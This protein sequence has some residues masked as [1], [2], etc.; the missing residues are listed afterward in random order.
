M[1]TLLK[2]RNLALVDELTW[3]PERGFLAITGETGAGKS[4]IMGGISLVLGERADKGRIRSGES[5]CTV[6]AVFHLPHA[7]T[8]NAWLEEAGV[9]PCEENDL[10]I[11][12]V[13]TAGGNRQFVNNTP[14]TL[15]LLRQIGGGLVD[16]H[17]PEANR[18]LVSRERQLDLLDAFAADAP[19]LGA[20]RQAYRAWLDARAACRDLRESEMGNEREQD[21]LSHQVREIEEAAFTAD[22]IAGLEER[23]QR[24][25]NAG[26][27][28]DLALPMAQSLDG[29]D[30][31]VLPRLHQLMR[32]ARELER[33]DASTAARLAP[34]EGVISELEELAADLQDYAEGLNGDPGE[35]AQLEERISLLDTLKRKYGSD[36]EAIQAHLAECRDKLDRMEHRGEKLAE[37]EAAEKECCAAM[38][39]AA[40]A[41]GAA[42]RKAAP[43]LQRSFLTHAAQLG[44][45][46]SFFELRF[47]PLPE[48]G[49]HGAEQVD[50][51][52]GP[53][54]GEPLKELRLI[55]SGGEMARV[56][57][58]LKSALAA[59]DDTP[60]LVFDEIDAN[61]GGEIARA[62]GC[63]MRE[64]GR[65]HQVIAIT[66]FPQVAAL[67]DHHYLIA[68]NT[69][70]GRTVSRLCE[71]DHEARVKELMRMLGTPGPSAEAHARELLATR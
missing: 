60:L 23:W 11:R 67:A 18:S 45:R 28:R 47:T 27:L 1:L 8:L 52:F 56:M 16:M 59:Q 44:F 19:Q 57:L 33:L 66:H 14:V 30:E 71:P 63:K 35:L 31:G 48:P 22:E 24:A 25:R 46:Q 40:S 2:I 41:L 70:A 5:Q 62:V 65:T 21:F 15:Q 26:R 36:F 17:H 10:I 9:P 7:E 20:Y 29:G 53:N 39:A 51:L 69:V 58:A 54:P 32:P 42:R 49:P 34:L 55:A 64:L 13:I 6:E 50:F 37:L 12:R 43:R 4:V 68:K 38:Q 61:V 3:E